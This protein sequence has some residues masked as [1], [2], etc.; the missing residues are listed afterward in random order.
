MAVSETFW[1]RTRI[2]A[3]EQLALGISLPRQIAMYLCEA[4]NRLLIAAIVR[5]F[6]GKHHTNGMPSLAGSYG[7]IKS[8]PV[9][10]VVMSEREFGV[11]QG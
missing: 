5:R 10:E 7:A 6:G 3:K 1:M 8:R 2:K 9:Q 4:I 11:S